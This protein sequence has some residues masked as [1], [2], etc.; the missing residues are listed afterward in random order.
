MSPR[1]RPLLA[2]PGWGLLG[3]ALVLATA[4]ALWW[5][6]VYHGADH[7]TGLRPQRVR[8]HL[9]A[10]LAMPFV[11]AF[12]LAYLRGYGKGSCLEAFRSAR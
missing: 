6:L 2:W 10:E 12:I 4:V 7:L 8:I 9:D 5:M 3:Y 1:R 11:P